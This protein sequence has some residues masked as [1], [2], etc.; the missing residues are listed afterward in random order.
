MTSINYQRNVAC[1]AL[2]D[3]CSEETAIAMIRFANY[4][5][6]TEAS[7]AVRLGPSQAESDDGYGYTYDSIENK[8]AMARRASSPT[9]IPAI[10]TSG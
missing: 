1:M 9:R 10:T 4:L 8:H 5:V 7:L 6:T 2:T 3:K